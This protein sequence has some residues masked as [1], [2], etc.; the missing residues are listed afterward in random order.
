[1]TQDN[2]PI[3]DGAGDIFTIRMRDISPAGDGTI[4]RSMLYTT[5]YPN[6]YT[7]GGALGGI[8]QHC[9]RSG[10]M[11]S[12]LAANA[13]VY[14][15]QWNVGNVA[16]VRRVRVNAWTTTTAFAGGVALFDAYMARGFTSPDSGGIEPNLTGSQ[17]KM[18][19]SMA[20]SFA[21]IQYSNTGAITPS[22]RVVDADPLNQIVATVPQ[23]GGAMIFSNSALID[24]PM[25]EHPLLL[26]AGEGFVIR[27]TIPPVGTWQFTVTTEWDEIPGY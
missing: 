27:A 26:E 16:A 6:D 5:P 25:G 1:M 24:K 4:M 15:F 22:S 10:S 7:E 21:A 12:G 3:K 8:F 20:S 14:S 18:R 17:G 11:A 9:A 23:I 2:R 19:T 13:P